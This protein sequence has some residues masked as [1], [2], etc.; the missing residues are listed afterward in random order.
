[1]TAGGREEELEIR[2]LT[3][4]LKNSMKLIDHASI[5]STVED[6]CGFKT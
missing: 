2:E 6:D 1:M 3:L 4:A 5:A